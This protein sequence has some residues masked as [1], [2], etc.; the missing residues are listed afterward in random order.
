MEGLTYLIPT[1]SKHPRE[2][3]RFMEWA[4]SAEV[5][6]QQT[7]KEAASAKKIDL[8]RPQSQRHSI[9]INFPGQR[10][11]SETETDNTGICRDDGSDGAPSL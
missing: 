8:R 10:S 9:H 3:Y 4:M 7:L 6:V 11:R 5:Q 1:E 2:A